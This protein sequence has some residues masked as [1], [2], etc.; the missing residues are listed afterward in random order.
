LF[1]TAFFED[2]EGAV[3]AFVGLSAT[4]TSLLN[5]ECT[6]DVID[7]GHYAVALHRGPYRDLDCTYGAVGSRVAMQYA[8]SR[9]PIREHYLVGP[10][11]TSDP[12]DYRTEVMWPLATGGAA[13]G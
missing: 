4:P 8:T 2:G 5:G 10:D 3:T 7:G 9:A 11:V 12:A 13:Q 6:V 1:S